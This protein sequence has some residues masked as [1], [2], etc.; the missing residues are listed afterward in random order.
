MTEV[1]S[2]QR[3]SC[4]EIYTTTA[5]AQM[6]NNG[7]SINLSIIDSWLNL[8]SMSTET[9]NMQKELPQVKQRG[10]TYQ[11]PFQTGICP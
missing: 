4:G 10:Q 2:K 6:T 1:V 9:L 11:I 8:Y 5:K 3:F 7:L